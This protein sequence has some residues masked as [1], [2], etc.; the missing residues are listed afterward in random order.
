MR[1]SIVISFL[2]VSSAEPIL[3]QNAYFKLG[4]QAYINA[5]FKAAVMQLE[6]A[7]LLDSTN[8]NALYMLGYSYY[9]SENYAKS[10]ATFTKELAITPTDASAY[11]FR[12]R[13]K[14]NLGKDVQLPPA[15]REKYLIGAI[16]DLTKSITISPNTK[17]NSY[18]QNRGLAY[19]EY[20]MF[21]L[22]ANLNTF[23]KATGIKAL[24]ASIADLEKVLAADN[25]RNDIA[26]Q[27]DLTKEKLASAVGHH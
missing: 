2:I 6:K 19:R 26:T 27:L 9:H 16:V 11:Y 8:S 21:K 4:T 7:C 14:A 18:Y 15:D 5:D 20:G 10:I 23:N 13:A 22:Q 1:L 17:I 24:K 12:A 3:A 25:T